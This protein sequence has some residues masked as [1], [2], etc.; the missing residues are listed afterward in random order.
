MTKTLDL[1]S[2]VAERM[3]SDNFGPG[4]LVQLADDRLAVIT[5][6]DFERI[7]P[8]HAVTRDSYFNAAR[9]L[10]YQYLVPVEDSWGGRPKTAGSCYVPLHYMNIDD[11]PEK[12]W[13]R[14]PH[15]SSC[16]LLSGVEISEDALVSAASVDKKLVEKFVISE[17]V[18]PK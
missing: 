13:Y 10:T 5:H 12:E 1:R 2:R 4:A 18:D 11:I 8:N 15:N 14:D 9:L 3:I 6:V 7:V 16:V 17:I